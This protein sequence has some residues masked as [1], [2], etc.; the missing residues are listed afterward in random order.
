VTS[1]YSY[2]NSTEVRI[3]AWNCSAATK[4]VFLKNVLVL[5]ALGLEVADTVKI[6]VV[7]A[8]SNLN[9]ESLQKC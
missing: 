2:N 6:L 3:T 1:N 4:K 7:L 5:K 9:V 8:L